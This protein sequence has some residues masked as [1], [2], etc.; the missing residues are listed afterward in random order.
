MAEFSIVRFEKCPVSHTFKQTRNK[1]RME[2][3]KIFKSFQG[4]NLAAA[5]LAFITTMSQVANASST[6][7]LCGNARVD[8]EVCVQTWITPTGKQGADLRFNYSSGENYS[9]PAQSI[10]YPTEPGVVWYYGRGLIRGV[11]QELAIRVNYNYSSLPVRSFR[12]NLYYHDGFK[13]VILPGTSD[14]EVAKKSTPENYAFRN[15][16]GLEKP[17]CGIL[18]SRGMQICVSD[19]TKPSGFFTVEYSQVPFTGIYLEGAAR[20]DQTRLANHVFVEGLMRWDGAMGALQIDIDLSPLTGPVPTLPPGVTLGYSAVA[21]FLP[22]PSG[23][24][25]FPDQFSNEFRV[26]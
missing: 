10:S 21:N 9:F 5:A 14:F 8:L 6:A 15:G 2:L 11:Q 25:P 26:K 19:I 1:K 22:V 4:V 20:I 12:A 3:M 16:S 24:L 23:R 7:P 17:L 18:P 13:Y